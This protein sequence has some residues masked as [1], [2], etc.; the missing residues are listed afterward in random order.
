MQSADFWT[1]LAGAGWA[2]WFYLF[3]AVLPVNL[4][5]VYPDWDGGAR[6]V[7]S[8]I[9]LAG[10]VVTFAALFRWRKSSGRHV[11]FALGYFVLMLFPVLGF[12]NVY[13]HRY[14]LVADHW[15]YF[16]LPAI[17]ALVVGGACAAGLRIVEGMKGPNARIGDGAPRQGTRLATARVS[18][19]GPLSWIAWPAAALCIAALSALSFQQAQSYAGPERL[20]TETLRKN[21]RAWM[22]HNNLGQVLAS[23]RRFDEAMEHYAAGLRIKPE[24]AEGHNNLGSV[25][26]DLGRLDEAAE[27]FQAALRVDPRFGTAIYNLGNVADHRGNRSEAMK[28]YRR[29]LELN[30]EYPEAHNNLGCLLAAQEDLG[31]AVQHFR[32]ALRWKP[33][34]PDA[35]N[36][37]GSTLTEQ[38]KWLEAQPFLR[39]AIELD[40]NYADA[41]YNLGNALL[42][43]GHT[44][45]AKAEYSK[46]L[47]LKPYFVEAH[48]KMGSLC[49]QERDF[50]QALANFSMMLKL[51][52]DS[53]DAHYHL[54]VLFSATKQFGPAI[55]HYRQALRA[56]PDWPEAL[57]SLAWIYATANDE[58]LRDGREAVRMASR[59][60]ELTGR[61]DAGAL[62]T[63]AAAEAESGHFALAISTAQLAADLAADAGQKDGERQIRTRLE[64]YRQNKPWRD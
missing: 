45:E 24:Q 43:S 33:N 50:D 2:L 22:A 13:F 47:Q 60:A 27:Q 30:P 31:G 59:A 52:P 28:A 48:L 53:V 41:H 11:L 35:C 15:Q 20:W 6:S 9:P 42:F 36:N 62:D 64:T 63:L 4:S 51:R 14:S 29:A 44:A 10:A 37:L 17:I 61:K 23:Q 19:A 8:W 55:D 21:P 12:V 18:A 25:L 3:K 58:R 32:E 46:A 38:G 34:Y 7:L 39:R 1:H 49:L 16:S 57:N 56:N 40:P 5:F 54:G 26:M